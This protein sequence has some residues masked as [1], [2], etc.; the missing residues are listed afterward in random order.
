MMAI[1]RYHDNAGSEFEPD[2]EGYWCKW[3]DVSAELMK[4]DG[5]LAAL[6]RRIAKAER[7]AD[8]LGGATANA[9]VRALR[10]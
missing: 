2:D 1:K 5:E 7:V 8:V 10:G 4:F 6:Q 9:I 3:D